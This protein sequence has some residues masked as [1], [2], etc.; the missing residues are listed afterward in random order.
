MILERTPAALRR[1]LAGPLIIGA[2][3]GGIPSGVALLGLG[4]ERSALF[5]NLFVPFAIFISAIGAVLNANGRPALLLSRAFLT[6][7]SACIPV[8]IAIWT[9]LQWREG[10]E[11][12]DL[13]NLPLAAVLFVIST[14]IATILGWLLALAVTFLRNRCSR[15]ASP[16]P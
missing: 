16:Q 11:I 8:P 14:L 6:S 13:R 1:P 10:Y 12:L 7:L 3:V 4:L 2:L 15:P 9:V 5:F